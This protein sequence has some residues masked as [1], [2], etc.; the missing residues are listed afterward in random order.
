M[1]LDF[2]LGPRVPKLQSPWLPNTASV[3]FAY[4]Y[5]ALGLLRSTDSEESWNSQNVLYLF[6]D[7]ADRLE[8][9]PVS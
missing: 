7:T 5:I 9:L 3:R 2:G 8:Q 4:S 1:S 6:L